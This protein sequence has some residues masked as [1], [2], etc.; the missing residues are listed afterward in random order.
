MHSPSRFPSVSRVDAADPYHICFDAFG[1]EGQLQEILDFLKTNK[2]SLTVVLSVASALVA[3]GSALFTYLRRSADSRRTLRSQ[4]IDAISKLIELEADATELNDQIERGDNTP[5]EDRLLRVRRNVLNEQRRAIAELAV[6]MFGELGNENVADVEYAAVARTFA[7]ASDP[8]Q[9][10]FYWEQAIRVSRQTAYKIKLLG[11]HGD[12][13]FRIDPKRGRELYSAAERV[14]DKTGTQRTQDQIAWE[15]MHILSRWAVREARAKSG[16][17]F[18]AIFRRA[19]DACRSVTD[20]RKR[21]GEQTVLRL[22]REEID[23][24]K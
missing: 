8:E 15:K 2:E 5:S 11:M 23:K 12:F 1:A 7:A 13:L 22:A 19:Q 17:D 10:S 20:D 14:I 24:A 9:A 21:Q 3:A 6:F 4:L 18:E 16:E